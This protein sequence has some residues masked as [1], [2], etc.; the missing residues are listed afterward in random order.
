MTVESEDK[1]GNKIQITPQ[2]RLSV[3]NLHWTNGG[4]DA[5][6]FIIHANGYNSET[7]DYVVYGDNVTELN[8]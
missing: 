3:Q 8:V 4:D 5:V 2:F 6:H 7:L 1:D